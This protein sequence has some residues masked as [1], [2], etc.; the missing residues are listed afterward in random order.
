MQAHKQCEEVALTS[1]S[2]EH[3]AEY[4]SA[5]FNP[6]DFP[7]EL[8]WL[9]HD[10]TEG[11]PLFATNLL[12]YLAERGDIAKVNAHWSLTRPLSEMELEAPESVRSMIGKKLDVLEEEERRALQYASIEGAEFLSSI[13]PAWFDEVDPEEQLARRE[14]PS[15][16]RD[17]R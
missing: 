15:F 1:L 4:M 14:D 2:R 16:N 7:S 8:P 9:V 17:P 3:I 11:H 10:K 5:M 6:N 13:A 12:Q